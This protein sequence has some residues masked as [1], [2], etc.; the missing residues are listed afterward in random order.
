MC[1]P[2]ILG[3]TMALLGAGSTFM[4]AKQEKAMAKKQAQLEREQ[5]ALQEAAA[6]KAREIDMATLALKEQEVKA[7]GEA[8]K[9]DRLR[10]AQ[11]EAAAI[12]LASGEAG[13]LGTSL[14]RQLAATYLQGQHDIGILEANTESAKKQIALEKQQAE[15]TYEGRM[16]QAQMTRKQA[17][18]TK[19]KAPSSLMAGL[20]IATAG[21]S[22]FMSGYRA[23][24]DF[25]G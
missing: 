25:K 23:G 21:V 24:K 18:L 13:V 5:A 6:A 2:L 10:Q 1:D 22:G 4:S 17:K 3:G 8:E 11:K 15:A 20:N 14:F 9:F 16:N 19:K 7:S 12:R